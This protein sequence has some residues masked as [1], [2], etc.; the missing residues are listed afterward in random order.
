[1]SILLLPFPFGCLL[2]LCPFGVP[3]LGLTAT[4]RTLQASVPALAREV[5]G[6]QT[7][8]LAAPPNPRDF[9][10]SP[11]FSAQPVWSVAERVARAEATCLGL[12]LPGRWAAWEP[13]EHA[14]WAPGARPARRQVL[15]R[16]VRKAADEEGGVEGGRC[17]EWGGG[18]HAQR[19]APPPRPQA[20]G[21]RPRHV[22][23]H[24][25][26]AGRPQPRLCQTPIHTWRPNLEGTCIKVYL[27]QPGGGG[28]GA[29]VTCSRGQCS[30]SRG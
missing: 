30:F 10:R 27:R 1:M 24:G 28:R 15:G 2:F 3:W 29:A 16:Q 19:S 14:L 18:G 9:P 25:A 5:G 8:G 22:A 26:L 12:Y 17:G 11:A 7:V 23:A 20:K 13:A 21:S 4:A 6:M